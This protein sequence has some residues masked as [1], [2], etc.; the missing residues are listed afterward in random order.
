MSN[1]T[2]KCFHEK[3]LFGNEQTGFTIA[4]YKTED[5]S[6]IPVEAHSK[7]QPSDGLIAFSAVGNRLPTAKGAEIELTGKWET[8]KYGLQLS[9]KSSVINRPQTPEGIIAYL[10]SDLIKGIGEQT[11][12][13]IVSRFGVVTLDV[14]DKEPQ[15]LLEV[16]G[17]TETKLA[18]IMEGYKESVGVR[19]IMTACAVY[20]ITPK[21]AEKILAVYGAQAA[22]IIKS[23][24]YALCQ[25]NGF[26]FKTID[27]M[28][29]KSGISPDN[30]QR[31]SEGIIFALSQSQQSGHLYLS[32]DELCK[33]AME[34][35]AEKKGKKGKEE[36]VEKQR[37]EEVTHKALVQKT[38]LNLVL[39]ARLQEESGRIYLPRNYTAEYETAKLIKTMIRATPVRAGINLD[40]AVS[41]AELS[42]G[43]N[44][45]T[46]QREAVKMVVTN[47]FSI[48]TGGPGTGKT[49]V[50]KALL[51][52]YQAVVGGKVAFAAPT[53]RASRRLSE[54]VG[55][56][57]A[58]LHSVL[59]LG[60]SDSGAGEGMSQAKRLI[61]ADMLVIDETSMIDMHLAHQL[62]KSLNTKTRV[63]F[64]GDDNQLP[65]VGAGNVLRELLLC[66][67][68]PVT[69][70]NVVHRQAQTSRI[71]TN[72]HTILNNGS[73]LIY[74]ADFQLVE[75]ETPEEAAEQVKEIYLSATK[76]QG[77]NGKAY[78]VNGVQILAPMRAKGKCCTEFLNKEIQEILNPKTE[79]KPEITVGFK[80]FRL[81]DKV[82]QTKNKDDV[83][84]GDV[85][86]IHS[87]T[88]D[89][90][91]D[92]Q[93]TIDF[94]GERRAVYNLEE[95]ET[96][97]LAY[98]TTIHKSQGSE[99]PIVI[100][101]V[102]TEAFI[103]LQR[104]L[105]YTAI[106]RAKT[107]VILIG[108]KKALYMAI[109]KAEM[110]HRNTVLGNLV[111]NLA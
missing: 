102:L 4:S 107:K 60:V 37:A 36:D 51:A 77:D 74:G 43:I 59:G 85:G 31:V 61:D 95:M 15:R 68:V 82:M 48:I 10:S 70:L 29:K 69:K 34:L 17:I 32:S 71:N 73:S 110:A 91:G 108:Q 96:V 79:G 14:F 56:D 44:L 72:A 93:V 42:Q 106:T 53:G 90:G 63:V 92:Y 1:I 47:N 65:S 33:E 45:A 87:I 27:E 80:K 58:T 86:R 101:P 103:L 64:V 26:G 35:L 75:T 20:G 83:S 3:T 13:A 105:I 2:I 30:P 6:N 24:P 8:G 104:N 111:N 88:K 16:S 89:K 7:Y 49:T 39:E 9:V 78:G 18:T 81:F 38:I 46:Q 50:I 55:A 100:I 98:A 28:A 66:G 19:D 84:N 76:Q 67:V 41:Q 11:A 109:H 62:F 22:E 21:K 5:G 52:V 23:N 54:S 97:D 25:I 12:R 94:G 57:A 40:D 99:Y